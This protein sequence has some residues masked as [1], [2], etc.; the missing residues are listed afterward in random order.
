MVNGVWIFAQLP[1]AIPVRLERSPKA[2]GIGTRDVRISVVF[3]LEMKTEL[4]H[5]LEHLVVRGLSH[6]GSAASD[7]ELGCLRSHERV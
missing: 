1:K 6:Y 3:V 5:P 7:A 4:V 2:P